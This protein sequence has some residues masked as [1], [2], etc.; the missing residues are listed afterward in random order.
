MMPKTKGHI[1]VLLAVLV[2]LGMIVSPVCAKYVHIEIQPDD[3]TLQINQT[4]FNDVVSVDFSPTNTVIHGFSMRCG[5]GAITN[6]T[7]TYGNGS[8]VTGST[9]YIY[10]YP[11]WSYRSVE[12]N[13]VVD[14]EAFFD[15]T[16]Y[17]TEMFSFTYA[18]YVDDDNETVYSEGFLLYDPFF[19]TNAIETYFATP[20]FSQSLI[21]GITFQSSEPVDLT[22]LSA[23]G[24]V[25]LKDAKATGIIDWA[26]QFI[27]F[28]KKI[29]GFVLAFAW[30]LFGI[31][32][33]FFIKNLLLTIALYI[34][35]TMAYSAISSVTSRGFDV[36]RFYK[37]FIGLQRALLNFMME[38]WNYLIQIISSF[39]G[40]FRI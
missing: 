11:G 25:V 12:L 33:F 5:L 40:I 6:F 10:L 23:P 36:F 27:E 7:L 31:I 26:F 37:K 17:D 22:I 21:T 8:T 4:K 28:A 35:V 16:Q 24:D 29:F 13:S 1:F 2:L 39:R 3:E 38:I 30:M 15:A 9:S 20:G 18:S 34:G 19:T 14:Y 32:D